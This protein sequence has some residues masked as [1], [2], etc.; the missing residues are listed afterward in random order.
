MRPPTELERTPERPF[1]E[2]WHAQLF[3]T[4]HALS[5][6]G[7]FNWSDWATHFGAAIAAAEVSGGPRDGSNYYDVWLAAFERFLID[8][9]LANEVG[10]GKLRAAWTDAYLSTPHGQPVELKRPD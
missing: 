2:P 9:E 7:A 10:L 3:A 8:R 6:A 4:T 1:E 5:A